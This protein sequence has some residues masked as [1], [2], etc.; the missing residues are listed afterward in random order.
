[1]CDVQNVERIKFNNMKLAD[2]AFNSQQVFGKHIGLKIFLAMHKYYPYL[3]LILNECIPLFLF[4]RI[5]QY[6]LQY[7]LYPAIPP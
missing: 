4:R 7:L 5:K 2:M 3:M 6:C 1:M